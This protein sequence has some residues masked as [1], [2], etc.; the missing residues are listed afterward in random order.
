MKSKKEIE[1]KIKEIK[2]SLDGVKELSGTLL[3]SHAEIQTL[4]WVLK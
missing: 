1:D 3:I 2:K 4:E